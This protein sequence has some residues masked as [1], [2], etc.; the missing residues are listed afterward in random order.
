[1]S[2]EA[3]QLRVPVKS[4]QNCARVLSGSSF[5]A[6]VLHR[7]WCVTVWC[8]SLQQPRHSSEFHS[9][10]K[11]R[12]QTVPRSEVY[13]GTLWI[14]CSGIHATA[15]IPSFP[16]FAKVKTVLTTFRKPER[17]A[18]KAASRKQHWKH[19]RGHYLLHLLLPRRLTHDPGNKECEKIFLI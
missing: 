18:W 16:S 15:M 12:R 14:S 3:E 13:L 7:L 10:S 17:H 1:M 11:C 9:C 8:C 2:F 5:T 6:W 19:N 4:Q